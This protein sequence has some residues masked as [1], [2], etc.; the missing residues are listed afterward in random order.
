MKDILLFLIG[1]ALCAQAA[2]A[3]SPRC[4]SRATAW[5]V[6][7]K[8]REAG[9]PISLAREYFKQLEPKLD[10]DHAVALAASQEVYAV[11]PL[12]SARAWYVTELTRCEQQAAPS[13]HF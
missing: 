12:A 3:P 8:Y 9:W 2:A 10:I 4:V 11:V 6:F 1:A 13:E 5:M 7:A